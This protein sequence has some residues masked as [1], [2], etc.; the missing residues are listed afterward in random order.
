MPTSDSD[1]SFVAFLPD[2]RTFTE[3]LDHHH[4]VRP[5]RKRVVEAGPWTFRP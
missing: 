4:R 5:E 2:N 3:L 1:T